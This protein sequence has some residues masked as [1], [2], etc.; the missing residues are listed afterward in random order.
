MSSVFK[1]VHTEKQL[2]EK[3][4]DEIRFARDKPGGVGAKQFCHAPLETVYTDIKTAY[5]QENPRTYYE[6]RDPDGKCPFFTD[7][8]DECE[9]EECFNKEEYLAQIR[10]D[11]NEAGITEPW[12]VQSSCGPKESTGRKVY[13]IS[14]HI[15]VPGVCF[16][17]HRHLKEWFRV[18]CTKETINGTDRNGRKTSRTIWKLGKTPIDWKVYQ[19]GYWRFPMC[20]KAGST[21]VLRYDEEPMTFDVFRS[22]SIHFT[23]DQARKIDV[24]ITPYNKKKRK[25]HPT[26]SGSLSEDEKKRFHLCGD[27]VWYSDQEDGRLVKGNGPWICPFGRKHTNNKCCK[28]KKDA[29]YCFGCVKE[30]SLTKRQKLAELLPDDLFF[31][32]DEAYA[33]TM[34]V[35]FGE[36]F[37]YSKQRKQFYFWDGNVWNDNAEDEAYYAIEKLYTKLSM[38]L[39]EERP[40]DEESALCESIFDSSALVDAEQ[41]IRKAKEKK[42]EAKQKLRNLKTAHNTKLVGLAGDLRKLAREKETKKHEIEDKRCERSEVKAEYNKKVNEL[43]QIISSAG[44][45]VNKAQQELKEVQRKKKEE[46]AKALDVLEE[47][48]KL[49]KKES[50]QWGQKKELIKT[51]QYHHVKKRIVNE[52]LLQCRRFFATEISMDNNDAQ[53][54]LFHFKDVCFDFNTGKTR[55][56]TKTDYV[57]R[58]LPYNYADPVPLLLQE[59]ESIFQQIQPEEWAFVWL[60]RW[61]GYSLTGFTIAQ[62]FNHFIGYTASNAKTTVCEM[63]RVA[64]PIYADKL[65][66]SAFDKDSS[67]FAKNFGKLLRMPYRFLYINEWGKNPIDEDRFCDFVDGKQ[68]PLKVLYQ[69]ELQTIELHAK[70]TGTSNFD[71]NIKGETK[72]TLRRGLHTSFNSSFVKEGLEE[73]EKHIYKKDECLLEKFEQNDSYK[74]AL[75]HLLKPYAVEFCQTKKLNVP[76]ACRE[77][78]K[79]AIAEEDP[80]SIVFDGFDYQDFNAQNCVNEVRSVYFEITS[81]EEDIVSKEKLSS[82][83][84]GIASLPEKYTKW[85]F[86]LKKFRN[87]GAVYDSQKRVGKKKGFFKNLSLRD[88]VSDV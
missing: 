86:I 34:I 23:E 67:D 60:M 1:W 49:S 85:R 33:K 25:A 52:F 48:K 50:A 6:F 61:L 71:A 20:A 55:K 31:G 41:A 39:E 26:G 63:M 28:I 38:M 78:F 65:E 88:V 81:N 73:P 30:F 19:K 66:K 75:F 54:S 13:K 4:S 46:H 21:R 29:V 70:L 18:Q 79:E 59:V 12:K 76:E 9:S 64:F 44:V 74:L 68:F 84:G 62:V 57:S 80:F 51:L 35:W 17:N 7:I 2:P 22:L 47:K 10:T 87:K 24:E 72:G 11:F 27:L 14:F 77:A 58:T 45:A 8:D 83:I 56:R 53:R 69:P 40:K 42:E 36:D 37:L 5:D 3:K 43:Q 82:I 15:T 32:T 16:K